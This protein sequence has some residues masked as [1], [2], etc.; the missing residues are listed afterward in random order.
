[1]NQPLPASLVRYGTQLEDAMQRDLLDREH[2]RPRRYFRG[3]MFAAPLAG[4]AAAT[5]VIIVLL[6]GGPGGA[7]LVDR[8]YAAIS[9]NGAIVHFVATS[10]PRP[11]P[12]HEVATAQVWIAGKR[13]RAIVTVRGEISGHIRVERHE[14]IVNGDRFTTITDGHARTY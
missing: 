12:G 13:V 11:D 6:S 9:G 1:M 4:I 14:V 3:R 8:A 7:S 5:V 10:R 2:P